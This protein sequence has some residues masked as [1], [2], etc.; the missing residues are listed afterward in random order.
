MQ[1]LAPTFCYMYRSGMR[2][3]L[4]LLSIIAFTST[5][6]GPCAPRPSAESLVVIADQ[7]D[8]GDDTSVSTET[9]TDVTTGNASACGDQPAPAPTYGEPWGPCYA[10]DG[11]EQID[12]KPLFCIPTDEGKICLPACEQ[13][14]CPTDLECLGGVCGTSGTCHR[15]CKADADCIYDGQICDDKAGFCVYPHVK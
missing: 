8:T 15:G 2:I 3:S 1:T 4:T 13:Q 14:A 12:G 9:S 11:C 6:C 10:T 5:A 7:C